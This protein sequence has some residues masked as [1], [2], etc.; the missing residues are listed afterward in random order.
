[1]FPITTPNIQSKL[2]SFVSLS[3]HLTNHIISF[4]LDLSSFSFG[5][6]LEEIKRKEKKALLENLQ[7]S[8]HCKSCYLNIWENIFLIVFQS[9]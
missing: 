3:S 2:S 8:T 1:M 4:Y 6:D 7:E 9:I 5:T